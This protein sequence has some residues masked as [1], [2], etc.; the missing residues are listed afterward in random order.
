M[1]FSSSVASGVK[2]LVVAAI[3]FF[4]AGFLWAG[5]SGVIAGF[6]DMAGLVIPASAYL[7]ASPIIGVL[8]A[9]Y[10]VSEVS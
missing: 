6:L 4:G 10:A 2:T 7:A 8:V 5:L 1:T 9:A 3:A